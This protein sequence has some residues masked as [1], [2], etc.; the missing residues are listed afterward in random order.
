MAAWVLFVLTMLLVRGVTAFTAQPLRRTN[1]ITTWKRD[2]PCDANAYS[3]LFKEA[4]GATSRPDTKS[5]LQALHKALPPGTALHIGEIVVGN[6]I[7]LRDE[8][9]GTLVAKD[10]ESNDDRASWRCAELVGNVVAKDFES[11]DDRASWWGAELVGSVVAQDFESNDG[12]AS[13]KCAD[14]A[15]PAALK[16]LANLLVALAEVF[17][18]DPEGGNRLEAAELRSSQAP[19]NAVLKDVVIERSGPVGVAARHGHGWG[20]NVLFAGIRHADLLPPGSQVNQTCT[21][22]GDW[23]ARTVNG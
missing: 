13:W 18:A 9:E 19:P 12:R 14:G 21:S 5:L 23:N 6:R 17:R 10:F 8:L 2:T 7:L 15:A 4:D 22:S 11:N 3:N 20:A 16:E 1:V